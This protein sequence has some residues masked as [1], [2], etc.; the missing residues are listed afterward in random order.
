M[1]GNSKQISMLMRMAEMSTV[2]EERREPAASEEKSADWTPAPAPA[3]RDGRLPQTGK[4]KRLLKPAEV[5]IPWSLNFCNKGKE[6]INCQRGA[7]VEERR[8]K[9][10]K[11][12]PSLTLEFLKVPLFVFLAEERS[13]WH[14]SL[15]GGPTVKMLGLALSMLLLSGWPN[16]LP[17]P[18]LR[19][20]RIQAPA[21]LY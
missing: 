12:K 11:K 17:N 6:I 4:W 18:T 15:E 5:T 14:P 2:K 8:K 1:H 10:K 7:F 19:S 20:G 16:S 9:K 21:R 13:I 3:C